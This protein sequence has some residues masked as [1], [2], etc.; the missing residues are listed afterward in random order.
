MTEIKKRGPELPIL[1]SE[2]HHQFNRDILFLANDSLQLVASDTKDLRLVSNHGLFYLLATVINWVEKTEIKRVREWPIFFKKT[3]NLTSEEDKRSTGDGQNYQK[4][5]YHK[6]CFC[7]FFR[8]G[9]RLKSQHDRTTKHSTFWKKL[10]NNQKCIQI[11]IQ[12]SSL[13]TLQ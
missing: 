4:Y 9:T 3:T 8:F 1:R 12:N 11:E 7:L 6:K 2:I 13:L 5:F 10:L